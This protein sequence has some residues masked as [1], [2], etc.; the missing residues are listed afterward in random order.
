MSQSRRAAWLRSAGAANHQS[1]FATEAA[2]AGGLVHH[3]NGGTITCVAGGEAQVAFAEVS[4]ADA[5][6]FADD[7]LAVVR[8][9]LP[10]NQLGWWSL[11]ECAPT[12][13]GPRLLARGFDWGWRPNWMALDVA[14]LVED[15]PPPKGL[16]ITPVD[17]HLEATL[18]GHRLGSVAHHVC[19]FDGQLVGGVYATEVDAAA[20][21][22]GIG[23]ALTVASC[24][25]LRELGCEHVLLNATAMGVPVY[26]RAGFTLLGEAGQTWWMMKDRI[27]GQQPSRPEVAFVEAIGTGDLAAAATA[28]QMSERDLDAPL[29]CGLSPLGVAAVT[30]Q[31][32]SG[33]WLVSQGATPDVVSAW[34]LGWHDEV[35]DLLAK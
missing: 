12:V 1:F 5:S 23:T 25:R 33:R 9:H 24:R 30:K 21:R 20:R 3:R 6:A 13:L 18:D 11:N 26:L 2:Q 32:G 15:I 4:E 8:R 31:Q 16:V 34:D 35:N 7:A 28:L 10:L 17:G 27:E 29:T 22:Q 14:T 19:D